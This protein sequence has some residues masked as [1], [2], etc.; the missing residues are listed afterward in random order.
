MAPGAAPEPPRARLAMTA[1][2]PSGGS[3]LAL[4]GP[5]LALPS[6][7]RR[8]IAVAAGTALA[9][10][11]VAMLFLHHSP[12]DRGA[13][14]A[15][16][17]PATTKSPVGAAPVAILHETP[18]ASPTTQQPRAAPES[19]P[20]RPAKA[21]PTVDHAA[22][23][24]ERG[25]GADAVA[26]AIPKGH[27][28][29]RIAHHAKAHERRYAKQEKHAKHA[30]HERRHAHRTEVASREAP[31]AGDD[32]EA[33]ASYQ[34]G[35]AL[36]FAGDPAGAVAAYQKAV[37]LAP[38]DPI[39]YR[40]LGLAHEQQG[41]TAAAVRALRKYLKLAPGAAD[42]EIISRRITRLSQ[43]ASHK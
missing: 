5:T 19:A 1:V 7:S 3:T 30:R 35:N 36:L 24:V 25:A 41:E 27:A 11:L 13:P 16:G 12:S 6:R 34:R 8:N 21:A 14:I 38:A 2:L 4:A 33:R 26:T 31:A 37:E 32:G 28:K 9:T 17:G 22:G 39:G 42:R 29:V 20:A 10:V 15:G 43:A 18:A 23:D 40:G